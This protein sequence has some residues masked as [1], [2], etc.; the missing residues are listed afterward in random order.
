MQFLFKFY[1]YLNRHEEQTQSD[2]IELLESDVLGVL[3][4]AL[5]AHVQFVFADHSVTVAAGAAETNENTFCT[6][7]F[8]S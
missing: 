4:E 3:P 5:T 2:L 1:S 8:S 7:Q 6:S